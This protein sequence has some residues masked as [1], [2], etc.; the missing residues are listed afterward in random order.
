MVD[1]NGD[2]IGNVAKGDTEDS[3]TALKSVEMSE[4]SSIRPNILNNKA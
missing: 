2:N 1:D 3:G 4:C